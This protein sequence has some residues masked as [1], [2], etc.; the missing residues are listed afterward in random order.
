MEL[1][2]KKVISAVVPSIRMGRFKPAL[3]MD[4]KSMI[5]HI[6]SNLKHV[7]INEIIIVAGHSHEALIEELIGTDAHIVVNEI[8]INGL[9]TSISRGIEN[10][11]A[12]CRAFFFWPADIPIVRPHTLNRLIDAHTKSPASIIRPTFLG[13]YGYP[14][15]LPFRSA[16]HIQDWQEDDGLQQFLDRSS[17]PICN[18]PVAD[19]HILL[20]V[21]TPEDY[22]KAFV[23]WS[24]KDVLTAAEC[25]EILTS[26]YPVEERVLRHSQKVAEV[27]CS[28]GAALMEM[29]VDVDLDVIRAGGLLH[30]IA[31]GCKDHALVGQQMLTQMGHPQIGE[32]VGGH[33]DLQVEVNSKIT[34]VEV[35]HL[36]DKLVEKDT[37]ILEIEK[38]FQPALRKWAHDPVAMGH[39]KRRLAAAITLQ[40]K[41]EA[42]LHHSIRDLFHF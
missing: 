26:V 17:I 18:V 8:L 23:C 24:R 32:I 28:I 37:T 6:I 21:N 1:K 40:E 20:D 2:E 12:Q 25:E 41:I 15:L 38:R 36:A 42:A 39:I 13:E 16:E 3:P 33:T 11:S 7:G 31:K 5:R 35:V 10:L 34:E 19:R 29:G 9:S 14:L 22:R 27:A 4:S 30:D